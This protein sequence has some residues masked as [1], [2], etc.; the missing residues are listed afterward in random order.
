MKNPIARFAFSKSMPF[1]L[2]RLQEIASPALYCAT[3]YAISWKIVSKTVSNHNEKVIMLIEFDYISIQI[4]KSELNTHEI[5]PDRVM[6]LSPRIDLRR[7][8]LHHPR[9]SMIGRFQ[10]EICSTLST[11]GT[12]SI[13]KF[14]I[15]NSTFTLLY[16]VVSLSEIW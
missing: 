14:K 10:I 12:V 1:T 7:L 8:W 4:K 15:S 13:S 2:F 16:Y 9:R 5:G 11:F 3:T 6:N